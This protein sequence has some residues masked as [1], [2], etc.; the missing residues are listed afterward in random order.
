ML[1]Y[2]FHLL[3]SNGKFGALHF[4]HFEYICGSSNIARKDLQLHSTGW[5]N[6]T[7]TLVETSITFPQSSTP[8]RVIS[9][10]Q[11]DFGPSWTLRSTHQSA[12]DYFLSLRQ[13]HYS[14]QELQ[15]NISDE[16]AV[17]PAIL[18]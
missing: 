2:W 7:Y 12:C 8:D 4:Q 14:L 17:I 3:S 9:K 11:S 6:R 10:S 18:L 15:Q 1:H 16:I 5:G 13:Q